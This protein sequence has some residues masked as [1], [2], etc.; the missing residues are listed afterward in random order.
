MFCAGLKVEV[1]L[2]DDEN[3]SE[4]VLR[5]RESSYTTVE[6]RCRSA[7]PSLDRRVS[8]GMIDV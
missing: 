2:E 8:Q 5:L 7:T 1:A 3:P 4:V 6:L